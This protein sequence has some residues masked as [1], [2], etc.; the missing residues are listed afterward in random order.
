MKNQPLLA[1]IV[2]CSL[3]YPFLYFSLVIAEIHL[4]RHYHSHL[5]FLVKHLHHYLQH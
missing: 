5:L 1:L 3:M 4:L 2:Y